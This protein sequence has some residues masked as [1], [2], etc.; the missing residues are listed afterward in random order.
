VALFQ[1][2]KHGSPIHASPNVTKG[3][4]DWEYT[5][6]ILQSDLRVR[7]GDPRQAPPRPSA[8]SHEGPS[9]QGPG[10]DHVQADLSSQQTS[11]GHGHV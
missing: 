9:P 7:F 5:K 4:L 2:I 11:G 8:L 3:V 6:E 1:Q 10:A